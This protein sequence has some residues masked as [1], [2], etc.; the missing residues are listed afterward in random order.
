[1]KTSA[2]LA[3]LAT[4]MKSLKEQLEDSSKD[5]WDT[6]LIPKEMFTDKEMD[7][8]DEYAK[9]EAEIIMEVERLTQHND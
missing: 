7:G 9:Q 8:Y 2:I 6:S 5:F 4:N 3:I 1:M